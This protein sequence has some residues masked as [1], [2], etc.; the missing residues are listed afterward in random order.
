MS[1]CEDAFPVDGW[2]CVLDWIGV[3]DARNARLTCRL[4]RDLLHRRS[5]FA[6]KQRFREAWVRACAAGDLDCVE[7]LDRRHPG[8]T[9]CKSCPHHGAARQLLVEHN[10]RW[11]A[12][13]PR[14]LGAGMVAAATEGHLH[15]LEWLGRNRTEQQA[16]VATGRAAR[17]FQWETVRWLQN[18]YEGGLD[19]DVLKSAAL[20]GRLEV[21]EWVLRQGLPLTEENANEIAHLAASRG[22]L[23]LLRWIYAR[24]PKG[25]LG[26]AD[27][28]MSKGGRVE[29]LEWLF[30]VVGNAPSYRDVCVAAGAGN[31]EAVRWFVDR[32]TFAHQNRFGCAMVDAVNAAI[33][34]RHFELARY[35]ILECGAK[36]TIETLGAAAFEGAPD[37]LLELLRFPRYHETHHW[38]P[39]ERAV[40]GGHL[41]TLQWLHRNR[42]EPIEI[43]LNAAAEKGRL[44]ILSWVHET[45]V[46]CYCT[47]EAMDQAAANGHLAV[48]RWLHENRTEGGT[49]EAMDLAAGG[50]HL[51]IVKWLHENRKE[52][53]SERATEDAA[54]GG[55]LHVL[56]WLH[57]NELLLPSCWALSCAAENG[58]LPVVR[59]LFETTTFEHDIGTAVWGATKAG[60]LHVIKYLQSICQWMNT[61]KAIRLAAQDG[62]GHVV[63]WLSNR[64]PTK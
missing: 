33:R 55:H 59:W 61:D 56:R 12:V 42:P 51:E 14:C 29:T 8:W 3:A 1:F 50:G 40:H 49:C 24:F 36:T 26:V 19:R 32:V 9:C 63:L 43:C 2:A 21:F 60:H 16:S 37:D 27:T 41:E 47:T 58:H 57:S 28:A 6:S 62:H 44:D 52:G 39:M 5:R 7:F 17:N 48:V 54:E 13:Y 46:P 22:H 31:S 18:R 38:S 35:L 20:D 30:D 10:V 34:G 4:F 45:G 15:V 53:C 11:E 64:M 23:D 25:L